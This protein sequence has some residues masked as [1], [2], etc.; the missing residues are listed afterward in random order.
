MLKKK[1]I[2]GL[3]LKMVGKTSSGPSQHTWDRGDRILLCE[4]ADWPPCC[5]SMASGLL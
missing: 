2:R 5:N 4:E 3:L 1:K